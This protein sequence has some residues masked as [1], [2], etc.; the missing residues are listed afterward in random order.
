M[1]RF[2]AVLSVAI[3]AIGLL[4]A[5]VIDG[6]LLIV[7]ISIGV[8]ALAT[9]LLAV[10]VIVWRHE[11][12]GQ[13][14]AEVTAGAHPVDDGD[15]SG[16]ARHTA[17]WVIPAESGAAP[18]RAAASGT[19]PADRRPRFNGVISGNQASDGTTAGGAGPASAEP[20]SMESAGAASAHPMPEMEMA[21]PRSTR[22]GARTP[23][24]VPSPAV[25]PRTA[26]P[27][28]P[29]P[30]PDDSVAAS[31]KSAQSESAGAEP[32]AAKPARAES[33]DAESGAMTDD[34]A[35]KPS[36]SAGPGL[37][38]LSAADS[39]LDGKDED[40]PADRVPE[41][42]RAEHAES[43][44]PAS[45]GAGSGT[46]GLVGPAESVRVVPGIARYHR[47][48]CLLIR[49]LGEADLQVMTRKDAA[50]GGCV[51]CRACQPDQAAADVVVS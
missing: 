6:S 34:A 46:S 33:A 27:A 5:G 28:V 7:V 45:P 16:I 36:A 13:V 9:L 8:A 4:V 41:A 31:P 50:A 43:D 12:F 38:S 14:P 15:V 21:S 25:Q 23:D 18:D 35:G 26:Q 37:G 51:P 24:T 17:Q 39:A 49:F 10:A 11:I 30:T 3:I 44:R 48:D 2:G 1:I 20:G 32:A 42:S 29:R 40:A 22:S 19:A 47:K